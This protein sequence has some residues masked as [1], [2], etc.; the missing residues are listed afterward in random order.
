MA[1][2]S[3]KVNRH[4]AVEGVAAVISGRTAGDCPRT[5]EKGRK[6]RSSAT[7]ARRPKR[8]TPGLAGI[9][10]SGGGVTGWLLTAGGP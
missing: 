6:A 10:V 1:T 5:G 8:G 9:A 7:T 4:G 3:A 2:L